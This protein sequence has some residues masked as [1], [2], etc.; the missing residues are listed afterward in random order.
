MVL[1]E[2]VLAIVGGAD[3]EA[4]IAAKLGVSAEHGEPLHKEI[5]ALRAMGAIYRQPDGT[6]AVNGPLDPNYPAPGSGIPGQAGYVVAQCGH[7]IARSEW[8]A[9]FRNCERC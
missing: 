4:A 1:S 7:R 9:G 5:S 3:T 8:A 6:L 2:I